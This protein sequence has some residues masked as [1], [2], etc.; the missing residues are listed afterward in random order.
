M[1]AADSS[2][3]RVLLLTET[4]WPEIGGGE[5][6]AQLLGQ[7]LARDG[8]EVTIVARRSR[9]GLPWRDADVAVRV[10]RLPPTGPGRWRKWLQVLP[11]FVLLLWQRRSYD[12][13]LVSGYRLLGIAAM[14]A[15]AITGKPTVLKADSSGELS[16]EYFR[17]GLAR[18]GV[19]LETPLARRALAAR[20]ALLRRADAFVA[21][22]DEMAR[23]LVTH[24]VAVTAVHRIGNAVDTERFRP[25]TAAERSALRARLEL[26]DGHIV[27]YTGRLVAYK[28]LPA[29]LEAWREITSGTLV[30][31]GEQGNDIHGC[32][33]QLRELA[34]RHGLAARVRFV[35]AVADVE[36]WL[37]ASDVFAFPTENEA[38]G[39]S[40]VEAMA[41]GL[42]AVTTTVG[43]LRD[44]VADE[45]NA[46]VVAPGDSRGIAAALWRLLDDAE[47]RARLGGAARVTAEQFGAVAITERY[48][49]LFAAVAR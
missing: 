39:L 9:A 2:V 19:R 47:L 43:G 11:A 4:Y 20:N 6:Q 46:L 44:F 31:V 14:L 3:R 35:G 26:P 10:L 17:A 38:F 13:V 42:P 27:L 28:G 41:C 12:V 1:S 22:S 16:G 49:A 8:R 37:R 15:R 7:G 45:T 32:E 40:L 23:E 18:T 30:L 24:G 21:M 5:R 29:L 34:E 25:A 33:P 36:A 48:A